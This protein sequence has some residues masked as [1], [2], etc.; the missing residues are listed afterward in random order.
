MC[1]LGQLTLRTTSYWME[2][3]IIGTQ[4]AKWRDKGNIP[5]GSHRTTQHCQ[6]R[7]VLES[8]MT[9]GHVWLGRK[10]DQPAKTSLRW[11]TAMSA[12]H[13][14]VSLTVVYHK[15]WSNKQAALEAICKGKAHVDH[16]GSIAAKKK[17]RCYALSSLTHTSQRDAR[18]HTWRQIFC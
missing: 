10:C 8:V 12:Q 6:Q 11:E 1:N 7:L 2:R 4:G 17:L 3:L 18:M 14:C 5:E 15:G 13:L 16:I 9:L